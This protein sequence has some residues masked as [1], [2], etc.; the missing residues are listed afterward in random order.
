MVR[1]SLE[2]RGAMNQ[3]MARLRAEVYS[4]IERPT[5]GRPAITNDNMFI[6]E[7]IREYL[8]FNKYQYTS[9][10]LCVGNGTSFG[11]AGIRWCKGKLKYKPTARSIIVIIL[12]SRT[13]FNFKL[14]QS[15]LA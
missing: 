14:W 12:L 10:L 7:L 5:E 11:A 4:A 1:E 13:I 2:Q 15:N 3:I 9:P 6:N 8:V